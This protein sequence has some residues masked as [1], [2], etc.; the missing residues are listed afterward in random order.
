MNPRSGVFASRPI[1]AVLRI[2]QILRQPHWAAV[3]GITTVCALTAATAVQGA[4]ILAYLLAAFLLMVAL[5]L[6][7]VD[8]LSP[9]AGIKSILHVPHW[10]N[11]VVALAC[12]GAAVGFMRIAVQLEQYVKRLSEA[13]HGD[14][15][16]MTAL[17]IATVCLTFAACSLAFIT[18]RSKAEIA[19]VYASGLAFTR[20]PLRGEQIDYW[21][22]VVAT[23]SL[24]VI[25]LLPAAL[26]ANWA[27]NVLASV[28]LPV[29]IV[30]FGRAKSNSNL[31]T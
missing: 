15:N 18:L 19:T 7:G 13:V 17:L 6:L 10:K 24:C 16:L 28:I 4:E 31:N 25:A 3:V 11:M 9:M 26:L 22:Q 27:W 1:R 8:G 5:S 23:L 14:E 2:R 20:V 30:A 12:T 21:R 29:F